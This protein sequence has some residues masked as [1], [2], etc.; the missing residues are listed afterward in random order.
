MEHQGVYDGQRNLRG[1]RKTPNFSKSK[2]LW[3]RRLVTRVQD[4]SLC[5]LNAKLGITKLQK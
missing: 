1:E 2:D 3:T 5:T 4:S